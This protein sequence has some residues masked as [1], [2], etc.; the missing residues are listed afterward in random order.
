MDLLKPLSAVV[1]A[2][3][4]SPLL[5]VRYFLQLRR[6][7]LRIPTTLLWQKST[8]DLQ[9]NVPFQRLR[10]S[11]LLMLQLLLLLLLLAALAQ[12]VLQTEAPPSA[13]V[14]LLIGRSASMKATE[15]EGGSR[16]E[17]ATAAAVKLG[18]RRG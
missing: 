2:G 17:A 1:A 7:M 15:V 6:Q 11:L 16:V 9:V 8:E 3:F 10:S 13:R 14:S 4:V 12:P 18:Q 5:L